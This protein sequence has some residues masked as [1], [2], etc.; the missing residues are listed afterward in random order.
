MQAPQ[1]PAAVVDSATDNAGKSPGTTPAAPLR[2]PNRSGSGL[3]PALIVVG[4]AALILILFG[5][6]AALSS[7]GPATPSTSTAPIQIP[8]SPLRAVPALSALKPV[9]QPGSPPANILNAMVLPE[10][11]GTGTVT[12]AAGNTDQYDQSMRFSSSASQGA[13]I[14]FY[15]AAMTKLGWNVF[16]TGPAANNEGFEVLGQKAGDDG[17]YWEMGAVI[18]STTFTSGSKAQTTPFTI[19]IF[20][21]PDPA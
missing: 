9:I 7:S 12:G 10:G 17:W 21:V 15:R 19:R 11:T 6:G 18:A 13:L 2:P 16:S 3:R 8:G 14:T 1:Q 20:Q 5:V 4:V